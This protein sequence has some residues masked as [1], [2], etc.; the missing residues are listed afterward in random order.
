M[1]AVIER[2]RQGIGWKSVGH[3]LVGPLAGADKAVE[4]I[5]QAGMER[6][7]RN[8]NLGPSQAAALR[9]HFSSGQV[10]DAL[11]HLGVHI[12][13]SAPI[14]IPGLQNLASTALSAPVKR[15][16]RWIK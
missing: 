10:Q 1:D 5:L 9:A 3:R 2:R 11:H 13:L 14:P 12:V 8:G 15:T 6:W 7:E 16:A 4:A